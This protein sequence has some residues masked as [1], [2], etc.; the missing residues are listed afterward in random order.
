VRPPADE[1]LIL[2]RSVLA[3]TEGV[4]AMDDQRRDA[5]RLALTAIA[6][7]RLDAFSS[8]FAVSAKKQ[9][10]F[11]ADVLTEL[12]ADALALAG[13]MRT[14]PVALHDFAERY[15]ADFEIRGNTARQKLGAAQH[16][17][18]AV[19][20]GVEPDYAGAAGWWRNQDLWWFAFLVLIGM[21][22]VAAE[23][24]GRPVSAICA[25]LDVNRLADG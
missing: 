3:V 25:E 21:I 23:R 6:S 2:A 22:R 10:P 20:A 11:P 15:L 16:L 24:T 19:H 1:D 7:E 5:R 17:V 8:E 18:V 9:F 4:S 13:A 12:A 14:Q